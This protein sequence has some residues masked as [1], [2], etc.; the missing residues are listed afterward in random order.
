MVEASAVNLRTAFNAA[1][2]FQPTRVFLPLR[3]K[4]QKLSGERF[5]ARIEVRSQVAKK[6]L[7]TEVYIEALWVF[8]EDNVKKTKKLL[9]KI[10][11]EGGPYRRIV[12]L[13]SSRRRIVRPFAQARQFDAKPYVQKV[14][15]L[16]LQAVKEA[17]KPP[18]PPPKKPK[19]EPK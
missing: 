5:R 17:L 8:L 11:F 15:T 18:P 7:N 6:G 16:V 4:L 13:D 10:S 3:Q 9:G 12:Q 1:I 19:E 2:V 14:E